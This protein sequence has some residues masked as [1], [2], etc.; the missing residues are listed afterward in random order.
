[1]LFFN[2]KILQIFLHDEWYAISSFQQ[3][4]LHYKE[5]YKH[6]YKTNMPYKEPCL[7][8]SNQ[9]TQYEKREARTWAWAW[10]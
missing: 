8:E 10:T 7:K 2:H 1:M 9:R 5:E 4:V 6:N 3:M